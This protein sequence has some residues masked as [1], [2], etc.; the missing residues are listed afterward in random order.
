MSKQ[1][2]NKTQQNSAAHIELSAKLKDTNNVRL[3]DSSGVRQALGRRG[4]SLAFAAL[5]KLF[6]LVNFLILMGIEFLIKRGHVT[7]CKKN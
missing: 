3:A 5:E 2:G 7:L 4:C 6:F 1:R